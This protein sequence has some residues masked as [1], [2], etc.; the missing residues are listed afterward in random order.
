MKK[1]LKGGIPQRK[2]DRAAGM[3]ATGKGSPVRTSLKEN[4]NPPPLPTNPAN[5]HR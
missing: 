2:E 4:F 3:V 5:P 1:C